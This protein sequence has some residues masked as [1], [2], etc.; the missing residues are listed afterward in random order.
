[1][2]SF[3]LPVL[4]CILLITAGCSKKVEPVPVGEMSSYRDPGY[5]FKADYPKTWI[6]LGTTGKAVF[7]KSQEVLNK[8]L[9]PRNGEE[10]AQVTIEAIPFSGKTADALIQSAKD[11]LKQMA[12]LNPDSQVTVAGKTATRIS[13]SIKATTKSFIYGYET[14]VAGDTVLF[15]ID[16]EGYGDQFGAHQA[17]FEAI[18]KSFELPIY[19][20]KTSD[21]WVPSANLETY[22]SNFFTFKYP[23][24]LNITPVKNGAKDDF[25]MEMQAPYRMDCSFHIDVFGAQKLDVNKIWA[26]NKA[27]YRAKGELNT[28]IDGKPA[29]GADYSPRG[30]INSQVYFVVNNDKVIR[31]T[32]NYFNP[33][34]SIYFPMFDAMVK[35]IKLK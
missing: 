13:Y 26:Q 35:S 10:G 32:I 15:R 23:D 9:D 24:N 8:F 3:L 6:N 19:Q 11:D 31:I 29:L 17:V 22:S 27:H 33:Q 16:C 5:G 25:A 4:A 21:Q 18:V 7:T 1:M 2:K 20:A 14:F 28:T 30:D 34:K 12:Q